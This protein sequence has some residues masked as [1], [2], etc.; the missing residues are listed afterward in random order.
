MRCEGVD[1]SLDLT[2]DLD[3]HVDQLREPLK[4]IGVVDDLHDRTYQT[5]VLD[6]IPSLIGSP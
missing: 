3:V 5:Y 6:N 1:E 4:D 2:S